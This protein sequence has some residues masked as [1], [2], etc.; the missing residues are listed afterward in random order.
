MQKACKEVCIRLTKQTQYR[1]D[2][3]QEQYDDNS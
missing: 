3:F 2:V 1:R